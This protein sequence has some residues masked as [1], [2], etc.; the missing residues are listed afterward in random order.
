M[1]AFFRTQQPN[2]LVRRQPAT[3]DLNYFKTATVI[4]NLFLSS[5]QSPGYEL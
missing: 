4:A 3:L 1:T 5:I 2:Y